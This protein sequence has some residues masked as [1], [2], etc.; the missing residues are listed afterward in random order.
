MSCVWFVPFRVHIFLTNPFIDSPY[1]D[2]LKILLR[3]GVRIGWTQKT[4][5]FAILVPRLGR[6]VINPPHPC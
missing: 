6:P 2:S 5:T 1:A 3:K 4:F